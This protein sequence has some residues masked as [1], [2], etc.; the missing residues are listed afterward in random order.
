MTQEDAASG[1]TGRS[2]AWAEV[3]HAQRVQS[4]V[5]SRRQILTAG[6]SDHDIRRKLRRREWALIHAGIYVSHTG[7]TTWL[8]RAWAAVLAVAPAALCHE[9]AIRAADG[10]GRAGS[11]DAGPIHVAVDRTRVVLSPRGV[12]LHRVAA[13][14][15]KMLANTSPPR[16]RMEQAVIDVAAEADGDLE[17][18][19]TLAD[20]VRSRKTTA[21]RMRAALDSRSRIRRRS[22]LSAVL[23]DIAQGTCSTLE[24]GYL[25]RVERAHRL[26]RAQ[27]QVRDSAKGVVYRDVAYEEFAVLVELDGRLHHTSVR[28]RTK[29]LERDLDAA[30]GDQLTVRLGWGQVYSSGC[31]T[32]E[33]IGALLIKRGWQ[34]EPTTCP[35]CGPRRKTAVDR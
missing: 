1:H 27:R 13:F 9:S 26:P 16:Q 35:R 12:V 19:A 31:T 24:H 7:P 17:A 10:P 22:L 15:A 20:G 18:I 4:G 23:D 33:K 2:A 8:Q 34:G 5:I 21:E 3:V 11:N 30:L 14:E 28:D 6:L 32:A 25:E 29:D